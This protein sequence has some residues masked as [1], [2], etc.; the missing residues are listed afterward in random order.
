MS[1]PKEADYAKIVLHQGEIPTENGCK[2]TV[3]IPEFS[4]NVF[5]EKCK[6]HDCRRLGISVSGAKQIYIRDCEIYKMKGT[7][8]QGA[9]DIEDGYRLNQYINIERNNIYDNQGYNIVVVGGRYINIIQNKLANNSL[10]VGENVEKVI[11]NNNHLREV[12]CVL[13]GEVTL[14]II[15]CMLLESR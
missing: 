12:S 8:P 13:S 6:I 11:I 15:K 14:Q 2:I 9:I 1:V 4:K 5:V 7:A 10:V 3:R